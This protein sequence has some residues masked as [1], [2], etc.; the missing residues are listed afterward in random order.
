MIRF[1][2]I[3]CGRISKN[4]FEALKRQPGAEIIACCDIIPSRAKEA[5]K[6]YQIPFWTSDYTEM[7]RLAD[8]DAVAICTPS[9]LHPAHGIQAAEFGKH[10]ISEKPLAVR[11]SDADKLIQACSQNEVRLFVV[12]QNRLNPSIQLLKQALDQGR[13]GQLYLLVANVFWHRPQAYYDLADWRGTAALDGGAICNQASHYVDLLQWLGGPVESVRAYTATLARQIETE[14][15]GCAIFTFKQGGIAALNV[16]MLTF[17]RNL[18]GSLTILGEKG[19]VQIGGMAVNKIEHWEFSTD[20]EADRLTDAMS[21]S[22]DSV[23]GFGHQA[24]YRNLLDSLK[25]GVTTVPDGNSG[26]QS[27]ELIEAI[28][29]ASQRQETI[30]LPL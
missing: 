4:H 24:Y 8:L 21:T 2:L 16:T 23:Y 29:L 30:T 9:G 28:Y 14:D 18:Q 15:T 11:L 10:V 17:P 19:T 6:Q 22:P 26:R 13:F 7:L 20:E 25:R 3:G 12:L 27:L 1:G 5:A